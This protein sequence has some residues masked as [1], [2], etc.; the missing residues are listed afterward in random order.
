MSALAGIPG[1]ISLAGWQKQR[2]GL[3]LKFIVPFDQ[4]YA[5]FDE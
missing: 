2:F 3:I 4:Q 5:A 1:L